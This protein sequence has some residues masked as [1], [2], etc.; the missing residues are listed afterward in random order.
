MA[1]GAGAGHDHLLGEG[2]P[3]AWRLVPDGGVRSSQMH[4]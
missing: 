2:V 1:G 3:R 4:P